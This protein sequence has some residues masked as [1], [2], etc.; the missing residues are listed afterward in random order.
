M[1][2]EDEEDLESGQGEDIKT[3]IGEMLENDPEEIMHEHGGRITPEAAMAILQQ[4]Q[5][6]LDNQIVGRSFERDDHG[7]WRCDDKRIEIDLSTIGVV[8][9]P[10]RDTPFHIAVRQDAEDSLVVTIIEGEISK[11]AIKSK[12]LEVPLKQFVLPEDS[13]A[14]AF[15]LTGTAEERAQQAV[16]H[17]GDMDPTLAMGYLPLS[18]FDDGE[19][20]TEPPVL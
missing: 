12:D 16:K 8:D 3:L 15:F 14:N 6:Q 17:R 11:V 10:A 2:P 20:D 9:T 4:R 5:R 7:I 13:Y 1:Y 18:G 19:D